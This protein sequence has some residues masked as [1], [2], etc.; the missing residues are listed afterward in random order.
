MFEVEK[1]IAG[2]LPKDDWSDTHRDRVLPLIDQE[3]FR[4]FYSDEVGHPNAS[5]R[6]MVSL[7]IFMGI[8]NLTWR[9]VAFQYPRRLD[10][11]HATNTPLGEAFIE[12]TTLFKFYRRLETDDT[13]RELFT[14]ITGKRCYLYSS[15]S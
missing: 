1:I 9:A 15:Q 2:A 4:H 13:A 12:P 7:L 10:W 5:I 11:M 14:E 3:K 6:I 8:E